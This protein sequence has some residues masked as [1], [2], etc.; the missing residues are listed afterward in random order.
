MYDHLLLTDPQQL[1]AIED[2]L[3]TTYFKE[4]ESQYLQSEEGKRDIEANVS[5]RYKNAIE[6]VVPWVADHIALEGKKL[7]EIGCGT[8]SSTAAFA[9][10]VDDIVGYDINEQAV[11]G[12]RG[13]LAIMSL[14]NVA[15]HVVK[16]DDLLTSLKNDLAGGVDIILLFAVLEHQTIQER[17][18][19]ISL[20]WELLNPD[21]LLVV[22]E[23]PNLLTYTDLHTSLLPFLH[24]LPADLYQ[25]Y[26]SHS[27]RIRFQESLASSSGLSAKE[28]E[29]SISRWGR[30]VSYHDFELALG[31]KYAAYL[32][33]QGFEELI[34]SWFEVSFEEELLRQYFL[35]KELDVPLAF[36]REVLNLIFKKSEDVTRGELVIP[37][38]RYVADMHTVS[39]QA[40]YIDTLKTEWIIAHERLEELQS[41][42]K[43]KKRCFLSR[44]VQQLKDFLFHS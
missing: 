15:L 38:N 4:Y 27:E 14:Q 2:V 36:T 23:T 21:G 5:G 37:E 31:T 18:A 33:A 42:A 39:E 12:A 25:R 41:A 16:P 44:Q 34:L 32:V 1:Q 17:H 28:L 26:A 9:H 40:I 7:A 29:E 10:F 20:C 43:Q 24:L 6:H 8:G 30:G 35:L 22:T 13:R 3:L 11:A 19:T